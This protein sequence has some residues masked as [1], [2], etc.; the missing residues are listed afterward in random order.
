MRGQVPTGPCILSNERFPQDRK[1]GLKTA[2]LLGTTLESKFLALCPKHL[3]P[4]VLKQFEYALILCKS[5]CRQ[6][7]SS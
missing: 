4:G 7:P 5:D 6:E 3:S 2:R 1:L